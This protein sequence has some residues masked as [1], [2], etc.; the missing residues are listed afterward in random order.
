MC[1]PPFYKQFTNLIMRGIL[2]T[3]G[4]FGENINNLLFPYWEKEVVHN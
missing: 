1:P 3:K 2:K 4:I